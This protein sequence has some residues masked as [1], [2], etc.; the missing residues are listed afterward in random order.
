MCINDNNIGLLAVGLFCI[1]KDSSYPCS[2]VLRQYDVY[3]DGT[4]VKN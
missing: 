3:V 2:S 4:C 1:L